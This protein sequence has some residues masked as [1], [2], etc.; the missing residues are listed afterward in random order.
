MESSSGDTRSPSV[1]PGPS[2][3]TSAAGNPMQGQQS[4]GTDTN[5]GDPMRATTVSQ[6]GQSTNPTGNTQP[7]NT[8]PGTTQPGTTQ[9]G[10]NT[11]PGNTQPGTMGN[12][13]SSSTPMTGDAGV[14][15]GDAGTASDGGAGRGDGGTSRPSRRTPG[16][17]SGSGT[18]SGSGG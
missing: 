1:T 7:G 12:Q 11:Q 8:Q 2:S 3:D 16:R 6:S 9:P 13:D 15:S 18:G 17:G 4:G 5:S 14:P 10:S